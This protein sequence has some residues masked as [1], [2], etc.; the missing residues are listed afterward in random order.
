MSQA[1]CG[2]CA[3]VAIQLADSKTKAKN[4][5]PG[6]FPTPLEIRKSTRTET[7]L[8]QETRRVRV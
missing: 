8:P 3:A 7:P 4:P 5:F 1:T 6:I 2:Y